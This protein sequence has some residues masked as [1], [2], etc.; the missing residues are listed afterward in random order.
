MRVSWMC[1]VASLL[2][3]HAA[4]CDSGGAETDVDVAVDA[5]TGDAGPDDAA[6]DTA[7]TRPDATPEDASGDAPADAVGPDASDA[8]L[9]DVEPADVT[10]TFDG[11][12][13]DALDTAEDAPPDAD[14]VRDPGAPPSACAEHYASCDGICRA[15]EIDPRHCGA[16]GVGCETGDVCEHGTCVSPAPEAP[17][18]SDEKRAEVL[19]P[20]TDDA[21]WVTLDCSLTLD[22][23]TVVTKA[24]R[25]TGAEASGVVLDCQGGTITRG[26]PSGGADLVLVQA[27]RAGDGWSRPTDVTIRNCRVEGAIRIRGQ[28]SNG[29]APD[30]T[31]DSWS[32]GHRER[33]QAAAPTRVLFEGLT[34][35]GDGRIPLYLSPGVTEFTLRESEIIGES[36]S[37]IVYLDAE[38]AYN[39]FLNNR[40][41]ADTRILLPREEFAIDG[42]ADNVIAGNRFET[43]STGGIYIYRNCGEG[44]AVRHQTPQRNVIAGNTFAIEGANWDNPWLWVGSRNEGGV[45]TLTYCDLDEEYGFGSGADNRDFAHDTVVVGNRLR[46]SPSRP[47]VH[48]T[49][50]LEVDDAPTYVEDNGYVD[51]L[52]DPSGPVCV[53]YPDEAPP[54]LV[55]DGGVAT[56]GRLCR[57]GRWVVAVDE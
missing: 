30:V 57:E 22:A 1:A 52:A 43:V 46:E 39:R 34:I 13:I 32:I 41:D 31:T 29:Q 6:N 42:S 23:D 19:A 15:V 26:H 56:D 37:T 48:G 33:A 51:T 12:D 16:C 38:S 53:V 50:G 55:E 3:L 25:I 4:G 24:I 9:A 8:A 20:A 28:G 27:R 54:V 47:A 35:V 5:A 2:A 11:D 44:G 17:A 36:V 49:W 10:E 45:H 14:V 7:S 40:I 21:P 18:C